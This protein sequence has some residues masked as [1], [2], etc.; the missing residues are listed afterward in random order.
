MSE[1]IECCWNCQCLK[2]DRDGVD[3]VE[4]VVGHHVKPHTSTWK[5]WHAMKPFLNLTGQFT[6]WYLNRVICGL[7]DQRFFNIF[8]VSLWRSRWVLINSSSWPHVDVMIEPHTA[9]DSNCCFACH[10]LSFLLSQFTDHFLRSLSSW[11]EAPTA[12]EKVLISSWARHWARR[13]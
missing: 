3:V 13:P 10:T 2:E 9:K 1:T 7:A 8:F 12:E 6:R 4:A 11:A 5:S